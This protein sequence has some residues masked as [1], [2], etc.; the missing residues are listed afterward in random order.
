[1]L[2]PNPFAAFLPGSGSR[3]AP[4]NMPTPGLLP[5]TPIV[6]GQPLPNG[7]EL[8]ASLLLGGT[9]KGGFS[10]DAISPAGM[11]GGLF[12]GR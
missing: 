11:L 2:G 10:L 5:P 9:G 4:E 1:M 6:P 8:L 12:G 7:R 3:L